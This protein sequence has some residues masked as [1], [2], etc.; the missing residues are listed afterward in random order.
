MMVNIIFNERMLARILYQRGIK[1][2]QC[3]RVP[4]IFNR[5]MLD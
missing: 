2:R 1:L 3:I 5:T 4:V